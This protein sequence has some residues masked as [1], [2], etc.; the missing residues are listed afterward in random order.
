MTAPG[1]R[2]RRNVV[3]LLAMAV[4]AGVSCTPQTRTCPPAAPVVDVTMREYR[5][6]DPEAVPGGR[7]LF[8][9]RNAGALD[10]ELV[11][12]ALPPDLEESIDEQLRSSNRR[13]F[14][15]LVHLTRRTPGRRGAFALDL[16]SGRYAMICFLRDPD[17]KQHA[18]QGMSAEFRV[19]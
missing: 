11:V 17:G 3:A 4:G 16:A 6:D 2:C 13:A 5:Y 10:H 19:V 8:R 12:V 15:T 18:V 9:V 1:T 7:V 14:P